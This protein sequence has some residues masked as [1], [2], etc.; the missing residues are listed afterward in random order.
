MKRILFVIYQSPCGSIW[1]NEGF[2]T[3]FGM[4]GEDLEPS[5]LL[6][7]EA[8]VS[9]AKETE[10]KKLGLL[11][12]KM[13]QKYLKK[14]ET[15]IYVVDEDLKKYKVKEIDEGYNPE[16]IS[17]EKIKEIIHSNDFVIFM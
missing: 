16:I 11:S 10:P 1:V 7:D 6:M 14:Y 4:Y 9:V 17:L 2:R 5:I 15:R 12:L 13:V 8:V 3:A